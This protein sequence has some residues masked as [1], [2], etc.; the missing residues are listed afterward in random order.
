[1]E[2]LALRLSTTRGGA[3]PG[4][5]RKKSPHSGPPHVRRERLSPRVPVHVTVR[6]ER[7]LPSMRRQLL[8][9][10]AMAQIG[11]ARERFWRVVHFSIQATHLHLVVEV[12]NERKLARAM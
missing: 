10:N 2:Q 3:R 7:S 11:R 4:A 5:G 8:A 12:E 6:F 1:M 9:R